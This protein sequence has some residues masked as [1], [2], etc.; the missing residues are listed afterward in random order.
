V[1][2]DA[3]VRPPTKIRDETDGTSN[4]FAIGEAIRRDIDG[5]LQAFNAGEYVGARWF[6]IAADDRQTAAVGQLAVPPSTFSINGA[7]VHAFASQHVGGAHF[8]L[9]DGSV[10]FISQNAD[11]TT[12]SRIGTMNDGAI[13]N[14]E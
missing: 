10:R 3:T 12:I 2:G 9:T 8:L 11:Q 7:A 6:G 14:V 4:T 13:A 5:N 1:F